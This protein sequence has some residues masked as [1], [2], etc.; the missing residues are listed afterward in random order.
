MKKFTILVVEDEVIVANDISRSLKKF[1]TNVSVL[2]SPNGE[3]ALQVA[4]KNHPD[5]I[6]MDIKLKGKMDGIETAK[7]MKSRFN[8]PVLYLTSF[9][10][11]KTLQRAKLTEP[12]GYL[13]KPFDELTLNASIEMAIYK[14]HMENKLKQSKERYRN[15]SI[16][17]QTVR[18]KERTEIAREIHDE[19]GQSLTVI[20][21]EISWL[22]DQLKKYCPEFKNNTQSSIELINDLIQNVKRISTSLRPGSLDHLGLISAMR[23]QTKEFERRSGIKCHFDVPA[24][25]IDIEKD[26]STAVFRIFQEI[27]TN[28]ARHSLADILWITLK[29][30]R[31]TILSFTIRDNGIG[32]TDAQIS[33]PHSFGLI[34]IKEYAEYCSGT[35]DIKGKPGKGTTVTL[36]FPIKK[37]R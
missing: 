30:E 37:R 20:K 4:E 29:K 25:Q 36:K 33:A 35:V 22:S 16:H 26:L 10:D 8:I 11:N 18:E 12:Y 1:L 2:I 19:L 5:I 3:T 23:W 14:H 7:I 13:L 17:L 34:G 6:L 15:L 21:M 32:I 28:I 9:A 31:G 27:M 24:E